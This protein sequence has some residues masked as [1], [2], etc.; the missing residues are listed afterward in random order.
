[1]NT[2]NHELLRLLKNELEDVDILIN[3]Y[4]CGAQHHLHHAINTKLAQFHDLVSFTSPSQSSAYLIEDIQ[5]FKKLQALFLNISAENMT[6]RDFDLALQHLDELAEMTL[7]N[8][9]SSTINHFQSMLFALDSHAIVSKTDKHGTIISVNPTF[10]DISGYSKQELV[11]ENHRLLNS[12]HHP[13][14]FFKQMWQT[15]TNNTSWKGTIC[16]RKK[17]GER[18]WVESSITPLTSSVPQFSGFI[19]IRTD[20]TKTVQIKK[21]VEVSEARLRLAQKY[22]NMASWDWHIQKNHLHYSD[23]FKSLLTEQHESHAPLS[24]EDI[25]P[26]MAAH[27]R[28]GMKKEV[29]LTLRRPSHELHYEFEIE[30]DHGAIRWLLAKGHLI[31]DAQN[32][33]YLMVGT[34]QDI[35]DHKRL[36]QQLEHSLEL[37]Q[38]A[39]KAKTKFLASMTHELKTPLNSVIGYSQLL[40]KTAMSELQLNHVE[41]IESSGKYLLKLINELLDLSSLEAGGFTIHPETL[42]L[43]QALDTSIQMISPLAQS[44][45]IDIKLHPA[46]AWVKADMM[47]LQQVLVN[48]LSNAIK[49][50]EPNQTVVVTTQADFTP[51]WVRVMVTDQGFG[52]PDEQ[53]PLVFQAFQRLGYETS[54]TEGTG[55]GLSISKHL[56]ELMKGRV[57]FESQQNQGSSF[58]FELPIVHKTD[59]TNV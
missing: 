38:A 37:A 14:S 47:R 44:K 59:E 53:K 54:S 8:E 52:I 29:I 22:S 34:L 33:P 55:I 40:R 18:Y 39:N 26:K 43:S 25:L 4:R 20:I 50:S 10:C 13:S 19:S 56:I 9:Q 51:G 28:K 12:A 16:N 1:M 58:W 6:E 57:G 27:H 21:A 32:E 15:I 2:P 31:R 23:N 41:T 49:Y 46:D 24:V 30:P 5:P 42:N 36:E 3:K 11:G 7:K 17:N 45:A 35:S 48:L